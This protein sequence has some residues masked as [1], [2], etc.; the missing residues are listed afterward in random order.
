MGGGRYDA[1]AQYQRTGVPY[2]LHVLEGC[3]HGA[4]CYN[5]SSVDGVPVRTLTEFD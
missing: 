4:W 5:G 3:K 1:Q 2:V